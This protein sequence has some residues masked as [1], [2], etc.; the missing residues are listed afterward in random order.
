MI[1]I[2]ILKKHDHFIFL[3]SFII[4]FYFV[5]ILSLFISSLYLDFFH[6]KKKKHIYMNVII[7]FLNIFIFEICHSLFSSKNFF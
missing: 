6:L 2:Y 3:F 4:Y 7:P 1:T 5:S